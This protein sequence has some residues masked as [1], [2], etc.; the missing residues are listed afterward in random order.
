MDEFKRYFIGTLKNKYVDFSGRAT[1]SEFW[2]FI[3]FFVVLSFIINLLDSFFINPVLL[4]MT[5]ME[6]S[7]GGMLS[8]L[9]SL[10]MLLPQISLGVRRLHDIGKTGWWMLVGLIPFFGWLVMVY[11]FVTDSE[12]GDNIYGSNLKEIS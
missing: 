11:F 1:R 7:K 2:Y 9:F 6:A 4:G 5:P 12:A 8:M 3:L 10:A